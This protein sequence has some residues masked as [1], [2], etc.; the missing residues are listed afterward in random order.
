MA[1]TFLILTNRAEAALLAGQVLAAVGDAEPP[2]LLTGGAEELSPAEHLARTRPD[3]LFLGMGLLGLDLAGYIEAG[4]AWQRSATGNPLT[5]VILC[6]PRLA[7]RARRLGA[8]HILQRPIAD[9]AVA[10]LL[11][12]LPVATLDQSLAAHSA[13][14]EPAA[15]RGGSTPPRSAHHERSGGPF[16]AQGPAAPGDSAPR[17]EPPRPQS[18]LAPEGLL[19]ADDLMP[20]TLA[21]LRQGGVA[22]VPRQRRRPAGSLPPRPAS[23][24]L[25]PRP[26]S[27]S[28]PPRP[29]TDPADP[30]RAASE[31]PVPSSPRPPSASLPPRPST[32]APQRLIGAPVV[33]PASDVDSLPP[34]LSGAIV[35]SLPPRRSSLARPAPPRPQSG[36]RSGPVLTPIERRATVSAVVP[37]AQVTPA[38]AAPPSSQSRR[39]VSAVP[40]PPPAPSLPPAEG[41]LRSLDIP[42]LIGRLHSS[43]Y[44]GCL[45]LTAEGLSGDQRAL[46]FEDGAVIALASSLA[47]DGLPEWLHHSGAL[48]REQLRRAREV[49][50]N[51]PPARDLGEIARQQAERLCREHLLRESEIDD[52]LREFGRELFGRLLGWE[53]GRYRL[54]KR[55]PEADERIT[56]PETPKLLLEGLR[57]RA[58]LELLVARV[59]PESVVLRLGSGVA[60][61]L[62]A[63]AIT[64][65]EQRAVALLDGTRSLSEVRILSGLA[66]HACYVLAYTLLCLGAVR[67]AAPPP[68]QLSPPAPSRA[69]SAVR[70]GH[71]AAAASESHKA[72]QRGADAQ[73]TAALMARIRAKHSEVE[74]ADY[75]TL[76]EIPYSASAAVV[77]RAYDALSADFAP[78]RLP[79][80]CR[81]EL[82][83]ELT[84]IALVLDEAHALLSD[85]A[86]RAA[87]RANLAP[88]AAQP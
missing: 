26:A 8:D 74:E 71:S 24:S 60:K 22:A 61:S 43:R 2:A 83:A 75:F 10:E 23:A 20:D 12:R 65:A 87:Y 35:D 1:C 14:P 62:N 33:D 50:G 72:Q 56:L 7:E 80:R 4:R 40:P 38:A 46:Y 41:D 57:H 67:P 63:A 6:P 27:A 53:R 25:P 58:S 64:P 28:L 48:S 45:L 47:V 5:I 36:P 77:R 82:A 11:P 73:A 18:G 29:D 79:E 32:S 34:R 51:G 68:L 3:A 13:R 69:A 59:G 37:P 39:P 55:A 17:A 44:T 86:I 78:A 85:D 30:P 15:G 9:E 19:R 84:Q 49:L 76:L 31:A 16:H 42:S 81:S 66:D 54:L 70:E 88:A 52:L 21:L